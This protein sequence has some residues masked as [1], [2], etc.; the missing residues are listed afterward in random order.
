M[1]NILKRYQESAHHLVI[2]KV[3]HAVPVSTNSLTLY[4]LTTF[5]KGISNLYSGHVEMIRCGILTEWI[6]YEALQ[7]QGNNVMTMI[8]FFQSHSQHFANRDDL[9]AFLLLCVSGVN[10][11]H[12]SDQCP[13][14]KLVIA[15]LN[16]SPAAAVFWW[17]SKA[18][19]QSIFI[20]MSVGNFEVPLLTGVKDFTNTSPGNLKHLHL[21]TPL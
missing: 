4:H 9:K 5:L 11:S 8:F 3:H 13:I 16:G 18:S 12:K 21:S 14:W 10:E 7:K 20:P 15:A 19:L 1:Q 6:I 2:L 17:K